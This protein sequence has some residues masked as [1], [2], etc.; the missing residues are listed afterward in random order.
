MLFV[1][2][3]SRSVEYTKEIGSTYQNVPPIRFLVKKDFL[4]RES[5]ILFVKRYN[6]NS[7]SLQK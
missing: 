5:Y 6:W 1:M 2:G 7:T 3:E 4:L